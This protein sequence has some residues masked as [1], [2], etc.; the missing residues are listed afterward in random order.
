[1]NRN[2]YS[3][4]LALMMASSISFGQG[5]KSMAMLD[6]EQYIINL[7]KSDW[8]LHNTRLRYVNS[9]EEDQTVSVEE[10]KAKYAHFIEGV[11]KRHK[12]SMCLL[13]NDTAYLRIVKP[14]EA[15]YTLYNKLS[16]KQICFIPYSKIKHKALQGL[17]N[18]NSISDEYFEKL[19][20]QY[21]ITFDKQKKN[22][23]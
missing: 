13:V 5:N 9:H 7:I 1:M 8:V 6:F 18:K 16:T 3:F 23:R 4:F 22:R 11:C 15:D 21:G 12:D 17:I 20:S 19:Y 2:V 14:Y 10:M